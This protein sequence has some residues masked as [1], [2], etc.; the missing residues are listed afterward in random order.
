VN[1]FVYVGT[2]TDGYIGNAIVSRYPFLSTQSFSDAGGGFNALR[3]LALAVVDLPGVTDLGV[4]TAHLKAGST[5]SNAQQR[6]AQAN[7]NRDT[8]ASWIS[9]HGS[10]GAVLAG[11]FNESEDPDDATNWSGG[12]IGD[13][14]P[15]GQR[16]QPITT[17]RSAGFADPKPLSIKGNKDTIDSFSPDTRFDYTLYTPG[18]MSFLGGEVFDT[19]QYSA[20]QLTALNQA[21]G[22]SF[23]AGDSYAA[24]DHLPVLS[25]F[26]VVPEPGTAVLLIWGAAVIAIRRRS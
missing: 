7:A 13:L 26:S 19:K 12:K 21:N 22:T 6:Q 17:L 18:L 24:S 8:I 4:F 1:F 5:T 25:V 14:L 23:V 9:R 10:F 16:Y 3:G 11:D 2:Y 15:N 20:T